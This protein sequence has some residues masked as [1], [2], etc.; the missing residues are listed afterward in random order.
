[1]RDELSSCFGKEAFASIGI[2]KKVA[3]RMCR[4]GRRVNAYKCDT[5]AHWHVGTPVKAARF[6]KN[7]QKL[8][9]A[10]LNRK[11]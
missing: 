4:A 1:M 7:G 9:P 5:C 8:T 10:D 11:R 3:S 6:G 2:A